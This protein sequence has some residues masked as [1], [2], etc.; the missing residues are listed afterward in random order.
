[1]LRISFVC[2]VLLT[3]ACSSADSGEK[4]TK[5]PTDGGF[6]DEQPGDVA[7]EPSDDGSPVSSRPLDGMVDGRPF[8]AQSATGYTSPDGTITIHV[9]DDLVTCEMGPFPPRESERLVGIWT[10]WVEGEAFQLEYGRTVSIVPYRSHN[11]SVTLGRVEVV[12]AGKESGTVRLRADFDD[13]NH[14]EGEIDLV[15]CR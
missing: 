8:R 14:V 12:R 11:L 10:S 13:D 5:D 4:T 1:M 2:A 3:A 6:A 7:I 15:V 9:H